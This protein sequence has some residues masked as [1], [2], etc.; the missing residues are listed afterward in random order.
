MKKQ[1]RH[2][3]RF[4][5]AC[6]AFFTFSTAVLPASAAGGAETPATEQQESQKVLELP[7]QSVS[8]TDVESSYARDAIARLAALHL[9]SG[10][11]GE[12]FDPQ[13]PITRQDM[14]V[15]ISR[16][17]GLQP[18]EAREA[19]FADVQADSPYAPYMYGLAQ[20]DVLKGRDGQT[21]GAAE[22]LTRQE[23][24]VILHRLMKVIGVVP[25]A[26]TG[27]VTYADEQ[28]IADYA[29]E[30]V[31]AVTRQKWMQGANGRFHPAGFVTRAEAAVIATRLLDARYEQAEMGEFAVNASAIRVRAGES[32]QLKVTRPTGEKLPFTP[33]FAVDRPELGT[34]LPDGTFVA[35]PAPGKGNVTI[36]VGYR[37]LMIP[38]EI[39]E[40]V[41]VDEASEEAEAADTSR[42]TDDETGAKETAPAEVEDTVANPEG[43]ESSAPGEDGQADS[44]PEAGPSEEAELINIAPQ[45]FTSVQ[46]IGPADP[47]FREVEGQYPGP[48]GGLTAISDEWT[49]YNRQFG[50]KVTVVLPETKALER[51]N[52][53]FQQR[54]T[55]GI[56]LPKW[57]E[58]EVS[59]DGKAWSYAGKALH[60]VSAAEEQMVI[61]TLAISLPGIE[62]RYVRVSFPVE[63]FVFARQLEVWV[64][65]A[66]QGTGSAVLLP[67]PNPTQMIQSENT[68]RP[69]ENMLLAYTGMHDDLGT[70]RAEEFLPMVGYLTQDGY[71]LD[72]MFDTV[73]FLPYQ[74]MPATRESWSGYL[75]DLFR[76]GR[77]L[78]ALN[79][80]MREF[81]RLRGTLYTTPT[82]ENVVIA[83]P[84]PAATQTNFGKLPGSETSL[85]FSAAGIGEEKAYENRKKAVE[86]YFQ[87]LLKRWEK[88]EYSYLRL[89]G[90]YWFHEL[91]EDSAPKERELIRRTASMVHEKALRF[92]WIPYFGSP[93][94][95]EWKSL[96]FDYAFLQPNYYSDKSIP[97]ERF[98]G[99]MDA[100]QKYGLQIEIEGDSKMYRDPKFY[101]LYYNQLA[102]T[103]R[104]G[105]DKNTLH[106]Y[107]YGSKTLLGAVRSTDPAL[108]A[109]YDDTYKW[110]RGRFGEVGYGE[111][112]VLPLP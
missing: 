40:A 36:T 45:S 72:Q 106:A 58:V 111:Q 15:L 26:D 74:T 108:R 60:D 9:I 88:A 42:E 62:A 5:A 82:K 17:V 68:R 10:Q 11:G 24:A 46:T 65:D 25:A 53:T 104:L 92:Y 98:D 96:Y 66:G 109:I 20:L 43:E 56:T 85:S 18:R 63:V 78:D 55:S 8:F 30:A 103:H 41:A 28:E 69:V 105:L 16:V 34:V 38:V 97:L 12:R 21:L 47:F 49:G 93:G 27:T 13:R 80:A 1:K 51:V 32:Q 44:A 33:I 71:M 76:K 3:V 37:S 110:M 59:R 77:Q 57:L 19:A 31:A 89:E 50:R 75:D 39:T 101:Q 22:S 83:I 4:A 102:A 2:T 91:V 35:G 81:N 67:H 95:E 99:L 7:E 87:E 86:W 94:M 52:L 107:Y 84:Y 64:K 14:A 100:V 48:V 29:R 54:K 23:M 61:R 79:S 90:I 70:W 6:L 73:L 112:E